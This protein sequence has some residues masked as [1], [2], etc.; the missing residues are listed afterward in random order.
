MNGGGG[1]DDH[2]DPTRIMIVFQLGNTEIELKVGPKSQ[3]VN[4][5]TKAKNW[6]T[7]TF[8]SYF[9]WL[10]RLASYH[11]NKDKNLKCFRIAATT[12][13]LGTYKQ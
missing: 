2:Q 1:G 12:E 10:D 6:D 11:L 3:R 4:T 9:S 13:Q 5:R 8:G 7:V